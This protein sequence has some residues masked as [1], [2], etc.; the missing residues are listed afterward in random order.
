M[1]GM[2][3]VWAIIALSSANVADGADG[4]ESLLGIDISNAGQDIRI[5]CGFGDEFRSGPAHP[6]LNFYGAL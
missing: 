6:A 2:E 5:A 4:R 1:Q 3:R